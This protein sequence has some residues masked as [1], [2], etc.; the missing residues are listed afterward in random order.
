MKRPAILIG[1]LGILVAG[2]AGYF[3]WEGHEPAIPY[4]FHQSRI[5]PIMQPGQLY[6]LDN[7]TVV[8][9]GGDVPPPPAPIDPNYKR[10][11]YF[12]KLGQQEKIHPTPANWG[13]GVCATEGKIRYSVNVV[14]EKKKL[15]YDFYSGLPGREKIEEGIRGRFA[16]LDPNSFKT[17]VSSCDSALNLRFVTRQWIP[18]KGNDGILD[19][20]KKE[21]REDPDAHVTLYRPGDDKG[22]RT[23]IPRREVSGFP[24]VIHNEFDRSYFLLS[25]SRVDIEGKK[26]WKESNCLPLW[27][28]WTDG[29]SERV[30]LPFE[31]WSGG[32]DRAVLTRKGMIVGAVSGKW[33]LYLMTGNSPRRLVR[34]VVTDLVASPDG[35]RVAF[36]HLPEGGLPSLIKP[37]RYQRVSVM[38]FC[39][40]GEK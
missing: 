12:W 25:L 13:G 9:V 36:F 3:W 40:D 31:P 26:R 37:R 5:T 15:H 11:I 1:A 23:P 10:D 22:I 18:L 30:C 24:Q 17:P 6:W 20:G 39:V 16:G 32:I 21:P 28:L 35:C 29:R 14:D 7:E 2:V 33:G 19:F 8:F 27:K 4:R 34:E 38:D